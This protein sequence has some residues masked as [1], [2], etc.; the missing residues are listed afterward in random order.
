MLTKQE[1]VHFSS[2]YIMYTYVLYK[3]DNFLLY[4]YFGEN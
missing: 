1:Y 4:L 2:K 3:N